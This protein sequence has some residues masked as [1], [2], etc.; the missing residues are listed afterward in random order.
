MFL[1]KTMGGLIAA[2]TKE[3]QA[4]K[5]AQQKV[6]E[7]GEK[8][9]ADEQA[10]IDVASKEVAMADAFIANFEGLANPAE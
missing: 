4:V 8:V 2:Y 10:K 3:A 1:R 9:I 5:V 7:D 6:I